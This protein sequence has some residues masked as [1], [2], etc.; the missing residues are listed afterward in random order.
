M[1]RGVSIILFVIYLSYLLFQLVSHSH[2][3][4]D[5][6]RP[7]ET[8]KHRHGAHCKHGNSPLAGSRACSPNIDDLRLR[9]CDTERSTG[10][11]FRHSLDDQP[12][13]TGIESAPSLRY[14]SPKP[15][16]TEFPK[17][18]RLISSQSLQ[19][20]ECSREGS[21]SPSR[22]ETIVLDD[23]KSGI[24]DIYSCYDRS[25]PDTPGHLSKSVEPLQ[26]RRRIP[27]LS[28]AMVVLLLAATP[29]LVALNAELLIENLDGFTSTIS[30]DWIGLILLP[31]VSSFAECITAVNVSVKDQLSL[32]MSVA[33]GST[34]QT[35]LCVIPFCV[36][37]GWVLNKPMTL[38]FDPF[39]SVVLYISV[40]TMGYVVGDGKSNWLEGVILVCLYVI[41]AVSFWF[42]TPGSVF[43][44]S[45]Q[46]CTTE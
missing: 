18:I 5:S 23:E 37:S 40:N 30:K 44:T 45:L 33:I 19:S 42:Y 4:K 29:C 15:S 9:R 27:E 38:L 34:I 32:S 10:E 1:S 28:W 35:A 41:I 24:A 7:S 43:A 25:P 6:E 13:G 14:R 12:A 3:Y 22:E 21:P 46:V 39:E 8:F 11:A 2:L 20:S 26:L 31:M 16:V 36:L 17:S